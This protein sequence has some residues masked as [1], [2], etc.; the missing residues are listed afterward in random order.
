MVAVK[1]GKDFG[2][3][4]SPADFMIMRSE[5]DGSWPISAG[6]DTTRA[7]SAPSQSYPCS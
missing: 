3:P 1:K 6:A 7:A 5:I 4:G 2:E